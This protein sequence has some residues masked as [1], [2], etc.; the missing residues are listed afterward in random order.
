[1]IAPEIVGVVKVQFVTDWLAASD[2]AKL[3]VPVPVTAP[4]KVIVWS[5]VLTPLIVA[6]PGI[7]K[8]RVALPRVTFRLASEV[9]SRSR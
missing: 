1:M 3:P 7:D 6:L 9:R 8:F 4:V 5:P 2:V